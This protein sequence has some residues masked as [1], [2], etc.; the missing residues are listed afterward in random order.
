LRIF[1]A[2]L[3]LA[4]LFLGITWISERDGLI[5]ILWLDY[6]IDASLF[7]FIGL[8]SFLLLLLALLYN[9]FRFIL[10]SPRKFY[11]LMQS[12][13]KQFNLFRVIEGYRALTYGH[14]VKAKQLLENITDIPELQ[15][16]KSLTWFLKY[17]L[18]KGNVAEEE[19][20]LKEL[21]SFKDTENLALKE[22]VA[23]KSAEHQYHEARGFAKQALA[24]LKDQTWPLL[25]LAE[26][27]QKLGQFS[28]ASNYTTQARKKRLLSEADASRSLANLYYQLALEFLQ[29]NE[30][31][32]ALKHL[33]LACD[34]DPTFVI[35]HLKL[36]TVLVEQ[37]N[38]IPALK[39]LEKCWTVTMDKCVALLYLKINSALGTE[40]NFAQLVRLLKNNV[41]QSEAQLTLATLALYLHLPREVEKYLAMIEI[42]KR[43]QDYYDLRIAFELRS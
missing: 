10:C 36:A 19:R 40:K 32:L 41:S 3:L 38:Q 27:E 23:L 42:S 35:P 39:W 24:N 34:E 33:Q 20:Y 17:Q 18:A 9:T 37:G 1:I 16:H 31:G 5:T 4:G 26:L 7:L 29:N 14:V 8:M 43:N 25:A 12:R 15:S 21:L 28:A 22:L 6:K 13:K 2:L 30:G 11:Q